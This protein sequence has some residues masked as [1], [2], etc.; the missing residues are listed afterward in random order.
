MGVN[1]GTSV[2]GFKRLF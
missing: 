1:F 2:N